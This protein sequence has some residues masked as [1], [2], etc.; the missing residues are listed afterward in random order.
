MFK[1]GAAMAW[2]SGSDTVRERATREWSVSLSRTQA[3]GHSSSFRSCGEV[4]GRLPL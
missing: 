3:R 1:G 2:V 4:I